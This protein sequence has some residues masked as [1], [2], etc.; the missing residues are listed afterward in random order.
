MRSIELFGEHVIPALRETTA[1][2]AAGDGQARPAPRD[3]RVFLRQSQSVTP[4]LLFQSMPLVFRGDRAGH[5]QAL[6]RIDLDGD[7]GGTWWV[8]VADGACQVTRDTPGQEPDVRIRSDARTW[9]G[10]AKGT[11][12]RVPALLTRRLRVSGDRRKAAAFQRLFS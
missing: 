1:A 8:R 6:Y 11:R 5:L 10:L 7:G 12:R 2:S 4:E 9:V 3:L